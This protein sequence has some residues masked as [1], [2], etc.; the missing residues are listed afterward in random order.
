[1]QYLPYLLMLA[2]MLLFFSCTGIPDG[3]EPVRGFRLERYLGTWHEIARL[4]HSFERG[5]EQT[6]AGYTLRDDGGVRVLNRG[7][8]PVKREWK[9]AEGR[10]YFIDETDVGRL[11]VS[12]F[13]PFYASYNII[14]LDTAGYEYAL[15]CG[16]STS[17][18]W[19]LARAP[20]LDAAVR[21]R[22]VAQARK[23]GFPVAEL[24]WVKTTD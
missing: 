18:L 16:P 22:L 19:I 9:E 14:A 13:R 15:V 12:F 6:S 8:D 2:P 4:D 11:K 7:Y 17:Y 23:L 1:M 20:Q 5:L 10:A 24:I 3:A 21:E